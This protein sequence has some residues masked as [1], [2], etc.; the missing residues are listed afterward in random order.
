MFVLSNPHRVERTEQLDYW[1]R[2]AEQESIAAIRSPNTQ[3]SERHDAMAHA[4][5]ALARHL[6][7]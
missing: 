3:A 1:L 5:S 4:Y 2:R 7:D 6:L